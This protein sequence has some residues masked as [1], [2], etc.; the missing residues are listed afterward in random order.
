MVLSERDYVQ[1]I[2]VNG[3][4]WV[5]EEREEIVGFAIGDSRNGSI[6]AL[7]VKPEHEG[8][9]YGRQLHDT[10]VAWL[11][12]EGLSHLWLTTEPGTRADQFYRAAGWRFVGPVAGGEFRCEL[13]RPNKPM[14]ATCE[15]ARA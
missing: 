14:H 11:W 3:R 5:V 15:D 6:W 12:A 7:F 2:E 4:G 9:G 13:L 10:A 8:N 1:A